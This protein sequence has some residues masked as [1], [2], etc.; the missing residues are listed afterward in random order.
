MKRIKSV[1]DKRKKRTK[2]GVR[3]TTNKQNIN[4]V[5]MFTKTK[6]KLIRIYHKKTIKDASVSAFKATNRSIITGQDC[7]TRST[8][9]AAI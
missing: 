7:T 6:G 4:M 9:H 5:Y 2:D 8:S 1:I 3:C